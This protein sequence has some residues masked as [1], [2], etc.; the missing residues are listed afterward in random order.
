MTGAVLPRTLA[1]LSAGIAVAAAVTELVGWLFAWPAAF[2]G[3]RVGDV[4]VYAP[5]QFLGWR[6]LLRA[7]HRWII[8]AA[9]AVCLLATAAVVVRVALDLRGRVR[10]LGVGSGRWARRADVRRSNLL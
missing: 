3:V 1:W 8:E 7:E 4:A 9:S 2:G 6:P 5:G 10:P